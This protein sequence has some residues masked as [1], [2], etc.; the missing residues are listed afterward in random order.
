MLIVALFEKELK[1]EI[2]VVISQ[3][4][5]NLVTALSESDKKKIKKLMNKL[6]V[7][8]IASLISEEKKISKKKIYNY[9][10]KIKHEN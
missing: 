6:S 10:L 3:K 4:K 5:I 7:R 8:D 1:G 2:T 9:C